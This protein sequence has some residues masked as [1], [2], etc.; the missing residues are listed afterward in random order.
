M[1]FFFFFYSFLGVNR[2]F[3]SAC[4]KCLSY[5]EMEVILFLLHF[6]LFLFNL[7]N[8][9]SAEN[10]FQIDFFFSDLNICFSVRYQ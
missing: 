7:F 9:Y 6:L 2:K 8:N 4:R 5:T 3:S 1:L 10:F